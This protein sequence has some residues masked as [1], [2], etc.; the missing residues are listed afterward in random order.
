MYIVLHIG[1]QHL[2]LPTVKNICFKLYSFVL[3]QK[4]IKYGLQILLLFEACSKPQKIFEKKKLSFFI[5]K[6]PM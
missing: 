1:I 3:L 5:L 2:T 6:L 4:N